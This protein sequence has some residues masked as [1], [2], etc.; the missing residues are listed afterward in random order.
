M[1][2]AAAAF[3]AF[4]I[5]RKVDAFA[6]PF[7]RTCSRVSA[8]RTFGAGTRTGPRFSAPW[9]EL[10]SAIEE[11]DP[12]V[13]DGTDLRVLKYPHPS[14]RKENSEVS[15]E[16]IADGSIAKIAKEMFL[17]MYA[18]EG[19][20]LAA[21]QVGIN[22]RLMVYNEH[23]DAKKWLS[24]VVLVNPK[25]VEFSDG[26]DTATEGC[27]SFPGMDGPVQR[28]KWIKV[29][30]QSLKGKKIKKKYKGWE[31]RIFQHEYDHLDGITYIDR[32][33]EDARETVQPRLDELVEEFGEGGSL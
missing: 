27:L 32:L 24:E 4:I 5:S 29:E 16:E 21:P 26:T 25:I 28:S 19:V 17:V 9:T 10:F 22:K 31:A 1:K 30:A 20:G 12:G 23:G 3:C 15:A 33:S 13:V 6:H 14:L 2:M 18:A 8:Q 7:L 11:V